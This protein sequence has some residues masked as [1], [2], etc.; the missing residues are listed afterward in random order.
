MSLHKK[1]I[2]LI[3]DDDYILQML[4]DD[5]MTQG[6]DTV[7]VST[8]SSALKS[9]DG[10][11][12]DAIIT[13][14]KLDERSGIDIIHHSQQSSLNG[15]TPIFV[16]TGYNKPNVIKELEALSVEEIF[17]KPLFFEEIIEKLSRKLA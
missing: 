10:Q 13:D 3:D 14:I 5:F 4:E 16:I 1:K 12:F 8:S 6:A 15:R 2:L 9:I 17:V 7:A 11:R